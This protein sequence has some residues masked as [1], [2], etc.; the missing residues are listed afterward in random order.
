MFNKTDTA[1]TDDT[2]SKASIKASS[3]TNDKKRKN[4]R[5]PHIKKNDTYS[6]SNVIK[7]LQRLKLSTK[8]VIFAIAIGTLPV[9]GIGMISYSFGSKSIHKQII[10][11]QENQVISLGEIINRFLL[12]RYGDIQ[13]LSNLPFLTN[14]E[15]SKIT[16]IADKKAV[17]NSFIAAY[18]GYDHLAVFDLNG[19]III[20]SKGG[21]SSQERNLKYFQEVLQKNAPVISEPETLK[22]NAVVIYIAAPIK[23]VATGKTIAVVRTRISMQLL[24]ETIK[25]YVDHNDDYYLVDSQGKFFLSL[26][27]DLLGQAA[28]VIYPGLAKL[29]DREKV[30]ILTGV[31]TIYQV[32][33]L[34]SYAPLRKL[35]GLPNLNWQLI[36]ATDAAIALQPQRQFLKN[37]VNLTTLIALLMTLVAAWL[38]KSITKQNSPDDEIK[39]SL[40]NQKDEELLTGVKEG[41]IQVAGLETVAENKLSIAFPER[42]IQDSRET[43]NGQEWQQK[44]PLQ[45]QLL[46]LI[47]QVE[48]AA[49]GDLTVQA[50][51]KDGE[52]GNIANVFNSILASL[53]DIVN[54]IKQN[55][56]QINRDI[57][58]NQDAINC[59]TETAITQVEE[60]NRTLAK[61]EQMTKSMQA[62]VDD[63]Q[64]ITAMANNANY[65][66]NKS[67]KALDLTVENIL[68]L[69]ETVGE[70]AKKV[71]HLGESSQ[72]ISRVVSLINQIAVQ[73]NLLAI[74]AGIE[75]ARAGEEGQ[76][77]AVV[78]EE[79]GEL[80][81]RSAA[82]TQEI[83]Q[84]VEKIKRDT[85]EVVKAMEVGTNQVIESTQIAADAQH[86]LSEIVDISQQINDFINSISTASI[87]QVETSQAINQLMKNIVSI[88]EHTGDSSRQI[89][90]SLQK[91]AEISQQLENQ[92]NTFKIN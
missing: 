17:L 7:Y 40:G 92:V 78:A 20:Q 88:S 25:N 45:L 83:E 24:I 46:Q 10:K 52:I 30:D 16:S 27:Q 77:F 80:A 67:G 39:I 65:I 35:A 3:S 91:I 56:H 79:V 61:V 63:A 11:T 84:I 57:G 38:A 68:F 58:S 8:A 48:N 60:I 66:A 5:Q 19:Q 9:V 72:Q 32:P 71:Q 36:L 89:S 49:K 43:K 14:A 34:V 73:T 55:T 86:S 44:E 62:L 50:E 70:T 82:A 1:Q 22:N 26:Q 4:F 76:G 87:S 59:L 15:I 29:M 12:A 53:R 2:N 28:T 85:T 41:N 54:N 6:G 81:A 31:Q 69:Q 18:Q 64:E 47:K 21:T 51:V 37:I 90:A 75:A 74:N 23:D 13:I 42:A 33:Q